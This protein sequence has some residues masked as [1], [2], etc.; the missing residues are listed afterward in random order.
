M[1]RNPEVVVEVVVVAVNDLEKLLLEKRTNFYSKQIC[2]TRKRTNFV[3][4]R[5]RAK[6]MN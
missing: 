6:K 4:I 2:I 3:N 5:M 1:G